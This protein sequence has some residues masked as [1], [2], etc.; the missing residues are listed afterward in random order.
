MKFKNIEVLK[1]KPFGLGLG[2][3]FRSALVFHDEEKNY[4]LQNDDLSLTL[5][6]RSLEYDV[7]MIGV[8]HP[9]RLLIGLEL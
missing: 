5:I 6:V 3:V 4:K 2:Y 9:I 8:T 7:C 1:F